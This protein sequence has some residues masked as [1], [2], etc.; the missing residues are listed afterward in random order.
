MAWYAIYKK[1]SGDLIS[2]GSIFPALLNQSLY[3]VTVLETRPDMGKY[4]WDPLTLTFKDRPEDPKPQPKDR[5][6]EIL[7]DHRLKAL[8]PQAMASLALIL[9]E[10]FPPELRYYV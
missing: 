4:A 2:I 7:N 5:V 6:I 10:K 8:N 9:V 1:G 3:G